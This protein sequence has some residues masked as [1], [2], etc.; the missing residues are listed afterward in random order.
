MSCLV[1]R[2][3]LAV[4]LSL[5]STG[6]A[7]GAESASSSF[8]VRQRFEAEVS[9]VDRTA[10][11]LRLKT[12]AGPL[13][14]QTAGAATPALTKGDSVVVDV[15]LI[16]HPAPA[17]LPR[18]QDDPPP[19]VTQRVRGSVTAIQ[20]TVETVALTTPAGRLTLSVPAKALA[21]LR[22][23]DSVLLELTVRPAAEPAALAATE[24]QRRTGLAGLLYMLF[25]R[26]K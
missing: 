5:S 17:G 23:G 20:R 22:T 18:R 6:I 12:D 2:G 16:R 24:A 13:R 8:V 19:L 21:G 9:E 3:L 4:L 11:M 1:R 7:V 14:L 25:G 26:G 15:A 10:G